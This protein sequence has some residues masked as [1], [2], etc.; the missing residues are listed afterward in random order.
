MPVRV[1]ESS[2]I[3]SFMA[4]LLRYIAWRAPACA[5]GTPVSI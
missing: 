1:I 3:L 2:L 4:S 5:A